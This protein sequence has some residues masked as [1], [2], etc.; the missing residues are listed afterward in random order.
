MNAWSF[1]LLFLSVGANVLQVHWLSLTPSIIESVTLECNRES[2][3]M[4]KIFS[5]IVMSV[6]IPGPDHSRRLKSTLALRKE[7]ERISYLGNGEWESGRGD[8]GKS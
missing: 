3:K 5:S 8:G 6:L 2:S 1:H 7:P 4:A